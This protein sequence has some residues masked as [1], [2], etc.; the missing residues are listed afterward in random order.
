MLRNLRK[1]EIFTATLVS[2]DVSD[3]SKF[4]ITSGDPQELVG[5]PVV[6][7]ANPNDLSL[8]KVAPY[9]GVGYLVGIIRSVSEVQKAYN[10]IGSVYGMTVS[11]ELLADSFSA[12]AGAT[13]AA[14]DTCGFDAT[15]VLVKGTTNAPCYV[16]QPAKQGEPVP[17]VMCVYNQTA[18]PSG[19]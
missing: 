17:V 1:I 10:N 9:K 15:G 2:E 13:L 14:G 4:N 3:S 19:S 5:V 8:A 12:V 18:V 7:A 11:V 16:I 6:L